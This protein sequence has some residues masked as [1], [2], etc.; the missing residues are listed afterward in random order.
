MSIIAYC[1]FNF[2]TSRLQL[3]I[4]RET[5]FKIKRSQ[6]IY[7]YIRKT[8]R[9]RINFTLFPRNV[10]APNT[11]R[12]EM[13]QRTYFRSFSFFFI[14][15]EHEAH[16]SGFLFLLNIQREPFPY[17]VYFLATEENWASVEKPRRDKRA[18]DGAIFMQM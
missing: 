11:K 5:H 13:E 2:S 12:K 6:F 14:T 3:V 8:K 17:F 15:F 4:P 16:K 9:F 10:V 7:I 1:R 18:S